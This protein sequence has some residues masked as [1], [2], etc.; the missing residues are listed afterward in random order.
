MLVKFAKFG[1]I[2]GIIPH[3]RYL[4]SDAVGTSRTR[5]SGRPDRTSALAVQGRASSGNKE[6]K[7]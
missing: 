7:S 5:E 2:N 6:R 1:R 4:R 3:E